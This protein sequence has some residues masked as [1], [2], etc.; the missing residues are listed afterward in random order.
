MRKKLNGR[1]LAGLAI[2]SVVLLVALLAPVLAPHDPYELGV[3]YLHPSAEH[4]LGTND[5]GQDILSELIYGTRISLLIGVVSALAVTVVG[6][7]LG[8]LSG[9]LG[10]W[11]DRII[12]QV[13]NVAMALPSLP[14]TIILV[15]FL[16]A[17]VWNIILAICITAW[18]STARIIRSRVQQLKALPFIQIERTMGAS[19]PYI[20]IR[21]FSPIWEKSY[22]SVPTCRW[23]APCLPRPDLS[24]LGLGVIGQKSWGG[25]LHYA[26]FRNGIINGSYW[27]YVPPILCISVSVLGFMLLSYY[28]EGPA[29]GRGR[30]EEA[31]AGN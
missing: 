26:F 9:Y 11:T 21:I 24:F 10:G 14:L 7:A 22:S 31:N 4:P 18:T 23:A 8:I 20:M 12:M 25:I 27:W 30:K 19:G 2:L 17:S 6:T 5:I 13:T 28:G 15:A 29:R 16:D 3:P 1:V